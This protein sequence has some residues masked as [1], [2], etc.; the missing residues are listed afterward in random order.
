[1]GFPPCWCWRLLDCGMR[2][3]SELLKIAWWGTY[4][5]FFACGVSAFIA[6]ILM[7]K[8]LIWRKQA[9]DFLLRSC[10]CWLGER[11][12]STAHHSTARHGTGRTRRELQGLNT[13]R[14]LCHHLKGLWCNNIL[15][16]WGE[17]TCHSPSYASWA[18][19]PASLAANTMRQLLD[20]K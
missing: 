7:Q 6:F 2:R 10:C 20:D 19:N 18:G 1:M 4:I 16:I 11:S 15:R 12:E 13:L 8:A 5:F 14:P 3:A 9:S 17:G